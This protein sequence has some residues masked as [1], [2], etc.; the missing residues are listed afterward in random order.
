[1]VGNGRWKA[2]GSFGRFFDIMKL[3][4]PRGSFGGEQWHIYYL[5]ARHA[6]LAEREL[7]GRHDRLSGHDSWKSRT[8]RFGSNE[9]NNP[10]T[11]DV[12]T[13]Y[14]GA[15]RNMVQ[16]DI[17]PTQS[18]EFTLGLDH[19]LNSKTSVGARYVHNWVT[20]AIEDFGWN[21]GG[22]EFYFIGNPGFRRDRAAGLSL[23]AR[24]AVSAGQRQDLP[25][26]ETE[27]RLRRHRVD[28]HQTVG[29]SL[30]GSGGVHV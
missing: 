17:K 11:I 19:E 10:E 9:A 3:E 26:G 12:T 25:A 27:T 30:V 20:R 5:D 22:T 13:K 24:Q 29:E 1:M 28:A 6:R 16:D 14:F 4:L 23:G 21:E 15:P 2:Y 8:N 7:P 18:Q